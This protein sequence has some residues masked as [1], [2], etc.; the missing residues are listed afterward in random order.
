MCAWIH[1]AMNASVDLHGDSDEEEYEFEFEEDSDEEKDAKDAKKTGDVVALAPTAQ[2]ASP[3][4]AAATV[5]VTV[6]AAPAEDAGSPTV[7]VTVA[8]APA[9]DAVLPT[10]P[11][12][13]SPKSPSSGRARARSVSWG[14]DKVREE[15]E[16]GS[17][18][19]TARKEKEAGDEA[20]G[21][22]ASRES[23]R[24]SPR[25][26]PDT[27][28]R[29]KGREERSARGPTEPSPARASWEYLRDSH[30]SIDTVSE[31][32]RKERSRARESTKSFD[33]YAD[34]PSRRGGSDND[35]DGDGGS[36]DDFDPYA[37]QPRSS[38]ARQRDTHPRPRFKLPSARP[39]PTPVRRQKVPPTVPKE[40]Q[41][42]LPARYMPNT[43]TLT[44]G[45]RAR[46]QLD[47]LSGARTHVAR[48]R[49]V[50][51]RQL[52]GRV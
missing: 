20:T 15:L 8:A 29:E 19:T 31:T 9:E 17:N 52:Y 11:T 23:P 48:M 10:S 34:V 40:P 47:S 24:D 45:D 27:R 39:A 51:A 1:L 13:K 46:A 7:A 2:D 35:D 38:S 21:S 42:P 36:S 12:L 30:A 5:A 32:E 50:R 43:R 4:K 25:G 44:E 14:E 37:S 3:T 18:D 33:P 26:S 16:L 6:A 22:R 41:A 49:Q 28:L